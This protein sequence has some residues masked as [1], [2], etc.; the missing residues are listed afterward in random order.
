MKYLTKEITILDGIDE[1][2]SI[3]GEIYRNDPNW[4]APQKNELTRILNPKK[5][6]YFKTA[7]LRLYICYCNARPVSRSILVINRSHW[8]RWNKK[9]AFFGFFESINDSTAVK[10]LFEKVEAD[11]RESGAE[12]IEG[13]FNPNHY[14]E[15]GIL[16]DNFNTPPL[17]FESHNP[18]YYP[19]LLSGAG[20]IAS[21]LFHTRINSNISATVSQK[22]NIS[23]HETF[24][25]GLTIRKFNIF[26]FK[27]DLEI[28]RTINND[29][30]ENNKFF[31]PLSIEE[32]MFS[33]KYFFLVT[34][35]GLILIAEFNGKPVGAVQFVLNLNTIIRNKNGRIMPWNIPSLLWKRRKLKELIIFTAGIKKDFR[36]KRVFAMLL[37]TSL[38]IFREYSTLSTTWISDENLGINLAGLLDM[39]PG[40]HFAIFSKKL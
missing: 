40:K 10:N 15:L 2:F 32:Y 9:S 28:L 16:T 1:F 23:E 20:F 25:K 30:F 19:S 35:P 22:Y 39:Q 6:P 34:R 5:N 4:I 37:K 24:G 17:F 8:E 18:S 26:R 29:A 31:L 12:Y 33:S 11:S 38:K 7:T 3:P 13:P 21:E 14:S 36:N 27:R